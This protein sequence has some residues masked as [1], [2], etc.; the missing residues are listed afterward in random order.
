MHIHSK[1]IIHRDIKGSNIMLS[2]TGDVK[3]SLFSLFPSFSSL[4]FFLSSFVSHRLAA[5]V[6]FGV[7]YDMTVGGKIKLSGSAHWMAP[8]VIKREPHTP[9]VSHEKIIRHPLQTLDPG[10]LVSVRAMI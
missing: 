5:S 7:A 6:D 4:S 3:L 8:E 10:L 9:K 2:V 1:H